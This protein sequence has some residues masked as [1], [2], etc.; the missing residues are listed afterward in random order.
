MALTWIVAALHLLALGIG[1]GAVWTRY[2]AFLGTLDA[3][4][5]RRVLA[6]DTWWAVAAAL[7][8]LTGLTRLFA[9][10]DKVTAYYTS[11][12]LFW[13]KMTLFVVIVLHE[14]RPML[15]LMRWRKA[16][17]AGRAPDISQAARFARISK[18]QA[19]LVVAMVIAATGMARGFGMLPGGT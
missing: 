16:I 18:T 17:A 6:A 8:L 4:G 13:T 5:V 15:A 10:T 11:N 1:L 9:G 12:W 14:I 3:V 2:R 19:F 7:W